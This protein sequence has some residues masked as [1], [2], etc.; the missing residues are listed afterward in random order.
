M[1]KLL[2]GIIALS[3]SCFA[4]C[5]LNLNIDKDYVEYGGL[6]V[7]LVS[8]VKD[9]LSSKGYH[10]NNDKTLEPGE[11]HFN[12]T[13]R[14]IIDREIQ[15]QQRVTERDSIGSHLAESFRHMFGASMIRHMYQVKLLENQVETTPSGKNGR[16]YDK[17]NFAGYYSQELYYGYYGRTSKFVPFKDQ[18]HIAFIFDEV[19]NLETC[20]NILTSY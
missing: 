6:T 17:R 1:K 4:E 9:I 16:Y 3:G 12:L 8:E 13:I 7:E 14:S 18:D 15:M 11:T 2:T 19:K 5:N 20:K 10:V